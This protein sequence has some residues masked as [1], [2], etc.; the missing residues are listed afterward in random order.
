MEFP[1]YCPELNPVEKLW[2]QVKRHVANE[3]F[4]TLESIESKI[5]EVLS[6]FWQ[7]V[8]PVISLLGDNWLTRGVS[9]FVSQRLAPT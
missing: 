3:V 8:E 4:E 5:E 2:D 6:P 9:A 1:P 7:S